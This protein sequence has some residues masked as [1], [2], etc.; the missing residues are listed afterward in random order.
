MS[1]T[2]QLLLVIL[3]GIF[4]GIM[5]FSAYKLISDTMMHKQ[6]ERKDAGNAQT[7]SLKVSVTPTPRVYVE[8]PEDKLDD[9]IS[10]LNSM[11]DLEKFFS[12]YS[13]AVGWIYSPNTKI[14]YGIVEAEDNDYYLHR[15]Y[16]GSY[17]GS[18][19]LFADCKNKRDFSDQ[20]T[21]IYGH[22]M[23]D[24][25]KFASLTEYRK[26]GYYAEHPVMYINTPSMNYRV[27]I[28]AG[29][30]TDADS[31]CYTFRFE[32]DSA[33]KEY[34]KRMSAQ[35]DFETEVKID[36]DDRIVTLSTCSYE[37]YDARYVVMGKLVPIH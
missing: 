24:G 19:S 32:S 21:I 36:P 2:K 22:H 8:E 37:F 23:N 13:D 27:E 20:N 15:F 3:S 1:K 33:Y 26:E 7:Y 14:D 18:G 5:A 28:F 16:D 35:S 25:T 29:F 30:L 6:A 34:L 10:P 11:Y 4:V 12:D 9:E 31:E 17:S